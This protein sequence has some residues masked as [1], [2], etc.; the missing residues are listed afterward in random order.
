M[1]HE[2]WQEKWEANELGFHQ[3]EIHPLLKRY[4]PQLSLTKNSRVLVPLCGKSNDLLWL[5]Q[6]G[7]QVLGAELSQ[8]AVEAFFSENNLL[9]EQSEEMAFKRYCSGN[10][11]LLCGDFF[12][13][14]HDLIGDIEA[15]FDRAALVALP[16]K[17][18]CD[19]A[20]KI[21]EV[22]KSGVQILL[23]TVSYETS[24]INPPPFTVTEEEVRRLY[25]DWCDIKVLGETEAEL[26]NRTV[27]E[28]AYQLVVK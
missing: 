20:N 15:I 8:I 10:I 28:V 7:H 24:E 2:F 17:M 9:A 16:E 5:E 23:V 6:S 22:T 25:Q 18:R 19:Y 1:K 4:W 26:K 14:D 27:L 21:R 12:T 13:V 11:E 3:E